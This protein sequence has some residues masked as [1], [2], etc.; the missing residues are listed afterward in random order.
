MN[1]EG[2]KKEGRGSEEKRKVKEERTKIEAGIAKQH[3]QARRGT[4]RS[5]MRI[6]LTLGKREGTF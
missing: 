5:K 4:K 1:V 2:G 3:E 6:E